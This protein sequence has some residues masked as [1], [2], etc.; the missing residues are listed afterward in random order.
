MFLILCSSLVAGTF[1]PLIEELRTACEVEGASV[2]ILADQEVLLS[3]GYGTKDGSHP[4][5]PSTL[6]PVGSISKGFTSFLI[7]QLMEEGLLH[8]DDPV[9]LHIPYFRLK[10]PYTTYLITLRDYLSHVSGYPKGDALWFNEVPSREEIVRRLR[11]VDPIYP[12]R[13]AFLY[14]NVGYVVAGHAA[15]KATG[16]TLEEL[17]Q[18]RIFRP[19]GMNNTTCSIHDAKEHI[20]TGYHKDKPIPFVDATP[21]LPAG[22]INSSAD[23][24]ILWLQTLLR[25]GE[26]FLQPDTFRELITPHA[27]S[28]IV[29]PQLAKEVLMESYA[30]GWMVI[31]Y[32][33][34]IVIMHGGSID[35]FASFL[36]FLPKEQLGI[37]ILCNQYLSPLT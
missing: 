15:E 26:G 1:D 28:N 25:G 37:A 7:G 10:D 32:R 9:S 21:I 16:K 24:L 2:A 12:L 4:V 8:L 23:D 13:K 5:T 29:P 27:R 30:L 11:F 6:F 22:G 34:H 3:K 33:G 31:S 36:A 18:E 17:F 20:A 14:Q 35:G 19:L